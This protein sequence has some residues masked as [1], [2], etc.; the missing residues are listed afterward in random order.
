MVV[1]QDQKYLAALVVPNFE[2][3]E[4]LAK[5]RQITFIDREELL[6]NS[7]ILEYA[8]EQVQHLVNTKTGFK[9]FERIFKVHLLPRAFQV[10]V[11][12]TQ[13]L[14]IKRN[15]VAEIYKKEVASLF[16]AQDGDS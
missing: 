11:E 3:M 14:S 10:G 5:E 15:V 16:D 8:H 12:M 13:K 7:Q 4:Q 9:S 2:L 6:N 1:G